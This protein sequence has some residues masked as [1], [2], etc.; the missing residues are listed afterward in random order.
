MALNFPHWFSRTWKLFARFGPTNRGR[1]GVPPGRPIPPWSISSIT[2]P[3]SWTRAWPGTERCR[4][5]RRRRPAARSAS[6]RAPAVSCL[7]GVGFVD[8]ARMVGLHGGARRERP[9]VWLGERRPYF[10]ARKTYLDN[11]SEP[12]TLPPASGSLVLQQEARGIILVT[13]PAQPTKTQ[14]I[15][16]TLAE[17]RYWVP[18]RLKPHQLLHP[19]PPGNKG[20]E[21]QRES[22]PNP[23]ESHR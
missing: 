1:L 18:T 4:R 2:S 12:V 9:V 19:L 3:T 17:S 7:V 20:M 22:S 5:R 6:R 14:T 23:P 8:A 16:S 10:T 11:V 13:R 21:R 15:S